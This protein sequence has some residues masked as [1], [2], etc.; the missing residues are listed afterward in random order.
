MTDESNPDPPETDI[1]GLA[2]DELPPP[3]KLT[4]SVDIADIGPCKKHIKVAV[5][6]STIDERRNEKFSEIVRGTSNTI[7]GFRPGKAPRKLIERQYR[8][9]VEEQIKT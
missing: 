3:K 9:E 6:Q 7:A 4:Q 8:R 2:V 5:A 1:D